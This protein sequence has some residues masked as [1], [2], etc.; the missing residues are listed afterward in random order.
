[1]KIIKPA[2][3]HFPRLQSAI[4]CTLLKDQVQLQH[5]AMIDESSDGHTGH[6]TDDTTSTDLEKGGTNAAPGQ[7]QEPSPVLEDTDNPDNHD[8]NKKRSITGI[9]WA[10]VCLCIL[11]SNLL[12]GL[13]T[14]IAADIQGAVSTTMNN[15]SQLG[16]LGIGFSLGSTVMILPIGKAYSMFDTKWL[17]IGSLLN[18][19]AGS[20]LCGAAPTMNAL[21]VGRVWAGAGG[22]GMYL[23]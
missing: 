17:F 13:D 6:R 15:V 22:A 10:L 11:S 1:M 7:L 4:H 23:G 20:A 19:A 14:T 8:Y 18:F 21:I 16:W 2:E 5:L 12:Y 3:P 9:S